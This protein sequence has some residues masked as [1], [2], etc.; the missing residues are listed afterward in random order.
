MREDRDV[1]SSPLTTI[2]GDESGAEGENLMRSR[3]PIFVYATVS[4]SVDEAT[5]VINQ[6]RKSVPSSVIEMKSKLALARK[7]RPEL[8][9]AIA[10]IGDHGDIYMLDKRYYTTAL[11]LDL[12]VG[13]HA[14]DYD[15]DLAQSGLGAQLALELHRSGPS[16]VGAPRWERLL[17]AF[18]DVVR[19]Y[20]RAG[21]TAPKAELFVSALD[22]ARRSAAGD[23][24]VSA[25]FDLLWES[26]HYIY[27]HEGAN[28]SAIRE[29]DPMARSLSA[30]V[31]SWRLRL[32]D[33]PFEFLLDRYGALDHETCEL[34]IEEAS[35]PLSVN[36]RSLPRGDLRGIRF[37]DSRDDPRVQ[38]ADIL[39]GVGREVARMAFTGIN[40]DDLQVAVSELMDANGM[41]ALGSP[42]DLFVDARPP[43]YAQAWVGGRDDY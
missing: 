6:L 7:R 40:D 39:A 26:R 5:A 31:T 25:I 32:G 11:M 24:D 14:A 12:L 8:L 38:V 29:M 10:R 18:N 23:H 33:R 21:T 43:S 19:T 37:V 34:I 1:A 28:A 35:V 36:G 2:V 9:A 4:L 42:L 41:W 27:D 22:S 15:F 13:A 16:A 30:I 20:A 3:D 17:G